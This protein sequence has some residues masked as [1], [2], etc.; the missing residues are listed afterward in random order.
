VREIRGEYFPAE[1]ADGEKARQLDIFGLEVDLAI[2]L[3][4]T[5]SGEVVLERRMGLGALPSTSSREDDGQGAL[6]GVM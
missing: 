6:V 3:G 1:G 4:A 2:S 5:M